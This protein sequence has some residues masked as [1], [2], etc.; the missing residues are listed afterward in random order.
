M[1]DNINKKIDNEELDIE[2]LEDVVGGLSPYAY[3]TKECP[4]CNNSV[5]YSLLK[6][7]KCG[8]DFIERTYACRR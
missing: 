6:C 1:T 4:E 5:P 3:K 2:R 7:N 8:Y